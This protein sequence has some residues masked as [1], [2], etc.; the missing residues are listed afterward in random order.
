MI[1]KM[2]NLALARLTREFG[3]TA[4]SQNDVNAADNGLAAWSAFLL[5]AAA[6]RMTTIC[7]RL[8]TEW[9]LTLR[10]FGLLSLVDA[11]PGSS[12]REIGR[13]LGVDRTTTVGMVDRL[14]DRGLLERRRRRDDRRSYGLHLTA[15][16][17]RALPDVERTVA[18][19]HDQFL[20]PLS[21]DD[22]EL[23]NALLRRLVEH[24]PS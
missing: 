12:Q 5:R 22:R 8:V 24:Q 21:D 23:L 6:S 13:R 1:R 18:E 17:R 11:M 20:G 9:G 14:E 7:E 16:G 3:S 10:E 4:V 19:L 2:S 15:D